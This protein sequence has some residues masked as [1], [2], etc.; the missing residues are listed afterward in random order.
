MSSSRVTPGGDWLM[1]Q[2]LPNPGVHSVAVTQD[3]TPL[4]FVRHDEVGAV[5]VLDAVVGRVVRDID[6]AGI[7][8]PRSSSRPRPR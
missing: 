4:L 8:G 5:G 2:A 6:E 1:R 3:A 7:S